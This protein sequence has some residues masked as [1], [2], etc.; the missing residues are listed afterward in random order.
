MAFHIDSRKSI[1]DQW[2]LAKEHGAVA[3]KINWPKEGLEAFQKQ[4][5]MFDGAELAQLNLDGCSNKE[6]Q[7]LIENWNN[8]EISNSLSNITIGF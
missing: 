8:I 3:F 6:I 2:S 4:I 7:I 5:K 1:D